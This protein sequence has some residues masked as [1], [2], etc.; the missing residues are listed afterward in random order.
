MFNVVDDKFFGIRY[1]SFKRSFEGRRTK[2][3]SC[4]YWNV[5][6][7]KLWTNISDKEI[8]LWFV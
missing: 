5:V 7:K 8:I 1:C 4:N 2:E 6:Y 3:G